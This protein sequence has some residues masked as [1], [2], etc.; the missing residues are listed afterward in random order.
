MCRPSARENPVARSQEVYMTST[1]IITRTAAIALGAFLTLHQPASAGMTPTLQTATSGGASWTYTAGATGRTYNFAPI[2]GTD[3]LGGSQ[4]AT[5]VAAVIP[6]GDTTSSV[7][8]P[9]T[10]ALLGFPLLF[11]AAVVRRRR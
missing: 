5:P 11:V 3:W 9:G 7:P 2:Q 10:L 1:A 4:D 6:P 8:E